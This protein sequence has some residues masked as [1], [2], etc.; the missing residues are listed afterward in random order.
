M[1]NSYKIILEN[2]NHYLQTLGF[3]ETTIYDYTYFTIHF[4]KFIEQKNIQKIQYLTQKNVSEYFRH[5]ETKK[6]ERT[7][8]T[9][10]SSHLNR[11]F[12]AIDKFL[13]YL[14]QIDLENA[15]TPTK[16]TIEHQRKKPLQILTTSEMTALYNTIPYTFTN[17]TFAK[18]QDR[19]MTVKLVLD[20]CY[21]CGM[22][23]SEVINLQIKDIN[24]DKKTIHIKQSKNYKDRFIPM[25]EKVYKSIQNYLYNY[26][27]NIKT[28]RAKYIYPFKKATISQSLKLLL[29]E[30]ENLTLKAKKPTLHT[31]RHSIAT[32]LL[33][34]GMSIEN[35]ALLLG[36]STLESTK[37]YTHFLED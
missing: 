32:H 27:K 13:E 19:Q 33:Q 8:Q 18:K 31:L 30:T 10:S 37:I 17:Y 16:H 2:F 3:A 26:R 5:L 21:A 14:H 20:L 23:K 34:N 4:I 35:I 15:P 29:K 11:N 12:G 24:F 22:R 9:Y 7:K 28:D 36:H 1:K 25:T 6:G